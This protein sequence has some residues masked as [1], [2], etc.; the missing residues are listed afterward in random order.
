VDLH[1]GV[2]VCISYGD[3]AEWKRKEE[4]AM[5]ALSRFLVNLVKTTALHLHRR[6]HS[7]DV[8]N[9]EEPGLRPL[10][11]TTYESYSHVT[12]DLL[13]HDSLIFLYCSN[14]SCRIL[15]DVISVDC[16]TSWLIYLYRFIYFVFILILW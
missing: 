9:H 4:V 5:A 3:L 11:P 12:R 14:I 6:C 13:L 15:H 10:G 7:P 16:V 1:D 2:E 8:P